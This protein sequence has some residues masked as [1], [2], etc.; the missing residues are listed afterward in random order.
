MGNKE[1]NSNLSLFPEDFITKRSGFKVF[2]ETIN[3]FSS[4][5]SFHDIVKSSRQLDL[6][7]KKT[8]DLF[9]GEKNYLHKKMAVYSC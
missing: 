7:R 6:R 2:L 8:G 3:V 9:W 4:L 1:I 5:V